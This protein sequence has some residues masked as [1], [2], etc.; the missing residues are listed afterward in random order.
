VNGDADSGGRAVILVVEK[1]PEVREL[2]K[3]FLESAGFEVEFAEDGEVA[4]EKVRSL[5]PDVVITEMLV[6]KVD[7]LVLC[8]SIKGDEVS[9]NPAVLVFSFLAAEGRAREAGADAFLMKP[10]ARRALIET[11]EELLRQHRERTDG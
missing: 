3:Y 2:E 4:L 5:Q 1:E 7:G 6:P 8:R 9:G 11:V 10:L